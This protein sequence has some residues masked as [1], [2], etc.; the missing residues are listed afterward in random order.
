MAEWDDLRLFLAVARTGTL[1]AAARS[2]GLSQPTASRRVAALARRYG[3]ALLEIRAGRPVLTAVGRRV[4]ARTE[5]MEREA[6]SIAREVDRFDERP[7]GTVRVSAPEGVGLFLIAPRLQA[8][9][10]AHPAIDLLLVGEAAVVD[11]ARREADL[12]VRFVRPRQHELVVRKVASVA[13]EPC[14]SVD[15]LAAHPRG[16]DLLAPLEDLVALHEEFAGTPEAVWLRR[17]LP[18]GRVRVRVRTP[19]AVRAAVLAGA[20]VGLL[21]RHLSADPALRRLGGAPPL[22]RDLYLVHHR[23]QK[24]TARIHLAARFVLECLSPLRG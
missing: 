11:L 17:H 22:L 13:F 7:Q 5:R 20:G 4:L 21:S 9:R 23:S 12:A 10:K 18:G 3:A 14:A 2:L 15:Y 8:F 1:T 16:G 24:R 19:L 6:I